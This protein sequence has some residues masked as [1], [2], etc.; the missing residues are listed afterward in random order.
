MVHQLHATIK[1][2]KNLTPTVGNTN[3]SQDR[4]NLAV[5]KKL[6]LIERLLVNKKYQ[7]AINSCRQI[8]E[9]KPPAPI[10]QKSSFLLGK[11]LLLKGEWQLAEL[12]LNDLNARWPQ[13][14]Y[15]KEA[16]FLQIKTSLAGLTRTAD[17][18]RAVH[19][20]LDFPPFNIDLDYFQYFTGFTRGYQI[21]KIRKSQKLL[22][23][24]FTSE[25]MEL[26]TNAVLLD[27][28]IQCFDF[29]NMELGIRR[30][31]QL[32]QSQ[33]Q[34]VN[35]LARLALIILEGARQIENQH[36][37]K[38]WLPDNAHLSEP[39]RIALFTVAMTEAYIHGKYSQ[40]AKRLRKV[41]LA[42]PELAPQQIREHLGVLNE[43]QIIPQ[44]AF[45]SLERANLLRHYSSYYE[46]AEVLQTALRKW[47]NTKLKGRLHYELGRIYQDDLNQYG[48]ARFHLEKAQRELKMKEFADEIRWRLVKT[49]SQEKKETEIFKLASKD[50]AFS[51]AAIRQ[52]LKN[53]Q[54]SPSLLDQYYR[55]L[56]K[57]DLDPS[58]QAQIL[59]RLSEVAEQNH[60]YLKSRF[61]LMRLSRYQL[62]EANQRIQEN[63]WKEEIFKATQQKFVSSEP[64]KFQYLQSRYLNLLG[65]SEEA[66]E[67]L[68]LLVKA[69]GPFAEKAQFEL[70]LS[71]LEAAP[72]PEDQAFE[73][74]NWLSKDIDEEINEECFQRIIRH[75]EIQ[76]KDY[77]FQDP[78][79]RKFINNS[80]IPQY[81]DFLKK[82]KPKPG[83][84]KNMIQNAKIR[85]MIYT[86][87]WKLAKNSID[88]LPN[89]QDQL[90]LLLELSK[91]RQNQK[92]LLETSLLIHREANIHSMRI[93]ALQ[94]ALKTEWNLIKE[95]HQSNL[96]SEVSVVE[97]YYNLARI[98]ERIHIIPFAIQQI[99]KSPSYKDLFQLL[100]NHKGELINN[101]VRGLNNA[102]QAF[103][104][105]YP[106]NYEAIIFR[107]ELLERYP[108][109]LSQKFL[110][111]Q[112]KSGQSKIRLTALKALANFHLQ[113]NS[114]VEGM[115]FRGYLQRRI[116]TSLEDMHH[117]KWDDIKALVNFHWKLNSQQDLQRQISTQIN[118]NNL[119]LREFARLEH[120]R[121][122][123]KHKR[124][125]MV[126]KTI[127]EIMENEELPEGFR[128]LTFK[129]AYQ[130]SNLRTTL[131]VLKK[132]LFDID[133][134]KLSDEERRKFRQI[135]RKLNATAVIISLKKQIDW[136]DPQSPNN[137]RVFLEMLDHYEK[138]V[139][140][141]NSALDLIHQMRQYYS[142]PEFNVRLKRKAKRLK[143][144]QGALAKELSKETSQRLLA[145]EL[146]LE[147][148]RNPGR[149]IQILSDI[150]DDE[151]TE[152]HKQFHHLLMV[153]SLI[154]HRKLGK[155]K[156]WLDRLPKKF[157]HFQLALMSQLEAQRK[158][159]TY[160]VISRAS[161]PQMIEIAD[162][163]LTDFM[164]LEKVDRI[165]YRIR[166]FHKQEELKKQPMLAKLYLKYYNVAMGKNLPSIA[167]TRLLMT[168]DHSSDPKLIARAYYLLGNHY[169]NYQPNPKKAEMYFKACLKD[170]PGESDAIL[171]HLGLASLFE[172]KG[173]QNLALR[174][175][176]LLREIILNPKSEE[177]VS[178]RE[179]QLK[180]SLVIQ[181]LEKELNADLAEHPDQI[182]LTA[183]SIADNKDLT[184]QAIQKYSLYFRLQRDV[185]KIN[186]VRM[187][188]AE[189]LERRSRLN[190]A[191][192]LYIQVFQQERNQALKFQAGM[193]A[194]RLQGLK[195]KNF[196]SSFKLVGKIRNLVLNSKQ[197]RALDTLKREIITLKSKQKRITLRNLSYNHFSEIRK[198]KRNFYKSN[199]NREAAHS[200]EKILNQ[201]DD[202]QLIVGIHY[203][204]ARL[205]DLKLKSFNAALKHYRAFFEKMENPEITSEIL[206]RVAEIELKELGDTKA[207]LESYQKYLKDF[208]AAQKRL[209]VMF[210]VAELYTKYKFEYSRALETYEDISNAYPQTKWDEKAKFA[211]ADLLANRLSDFDAAIRV[212]ENLINTN[213][214]SKL[215]PE[216][217]YRIA[218]I[219]EIQLNDD[220]Q[221]I[222]AYDDLIA[223]YPNSSYAVQARRQIDKI[224]RR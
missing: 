56:L 35:H 157:K 186:P 213:F 16:D 90:Q 8:L 57:L 6:E 185:S 59:K 211:Q 134:R 160:P 204:L 49:L 220:L 25:N 132:W 147:K 101:P 162:L 128:Y 126:N 135:K 47:K 2:D 86:E 69:N 192:E 43:L 85:L 46:A 219:Y 129:T 41:S 178:A 116:E 97:K 13:N 58:N 28:L 215:A 111:D 191:L 38:A 122:L 95:S 214:E 127:S 177:Y 113:N 42:D 142:E 96:E 93:K 141:V 223:R 174:E 74:Q 24:Y 73:L 19:K 53:K 79:T 94:T 196:R 153:R 26:R 21:K 75:H 67:G 207:A 221:A 194:L 161:L 82:Q 70:F 17:F 84:E 60:Q 148:L 4:L 206:L 169:S 155:A 202:Y 145:A 144:M 98:K 136:D 187:E 45:E 33:E 22:E 149:A 137:K 123:L 118:S 175:Y 36:A 105:H 80:L 68:N 107:L 176:Q 115:P 76:L 61:Y 165:L 91:R 183:R 216:A 195:R 48:L 171:A 29:G 164:D 125:N 51:E 23:K 63:L 32:A 34:R 104:K 190:K 81:D 11:A 197:N 121:L 199:R 182:L 224:R 163:H 184:D 102:L 40:A 158:L 193:K 168:I 14:L 198:I 71:D 20:V 89:R 130:L 92:N 180:K 44:N 119:Y 7:Q 9:Q 15:R 201:A 152:N 88:K 218:S 78:A 117:P 170:S 72:Y 200:L 108:S 65:K 106:N 222:Q 103:S 150:S 203:E 133:E 52:Q 217:Q 1:F 181:K 124:F 188:L 154:R 12:T 120:L 151:L 18:E 110:L 66:R 172:S 112:T 166:K 212:Y 83:I 62:D 10:E 50:L 143:I 210:Q 39:G 5:Q 100:L 3:Q 27:G 55:S 208:P 99:T 77:T 140:D 209:S 139:E 87:K 30:L 173:F 156:L 179:L 146:W 167:A 54:I 189:L 109:R 131:P 205:Y 31:K 64:E 138:E 159:Q 37:M 114:A